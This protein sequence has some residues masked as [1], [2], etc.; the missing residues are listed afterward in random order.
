MTNLSIAMLPQRCRRRTPNIACEN[1]SDA[2][3]DNEA[4]TKVAKQTISAIISN[5]E[6]TEEI[7]SRAFGKVEGNDGQD[8]ACVHCLEN[9]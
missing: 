3:D 8:P 6:A 9:R 5:K 1:R 7:Y 4:E 2:T